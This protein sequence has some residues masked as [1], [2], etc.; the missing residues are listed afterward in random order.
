MATT[1][2]YAKPCPCGSHP[3][4]ESSFDDDSGGVD[5]QCICLRCGRAGPLCRTS[6]EAVQAWDAMIERE[7]KQCPQST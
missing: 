5:V 1:I 2:E 7:A 4:Y 6:E 3:V